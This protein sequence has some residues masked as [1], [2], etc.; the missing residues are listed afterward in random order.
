MK[1]NYIFMMCCTAMPELLLKVSAYYTTLNSRMWV[2]QPTKNQP[3]SPNSDPNSLN[4]SLLTFCFFCLMTKE[5]NYQSVKWPP[6]LMEGI[7]EH[8]LCSGQS[9]V[10]FKTKW[11]NQKGPLISEQPMYPSDSSTTTGSHRVS[12][13]SGQWGELKHSSCSGLWSGSS[14][15]AGA[16][17]QSH[18][19]IHRLPGTPTCPLLRCLNATRATSIHH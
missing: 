16:L 18:T 11:N 3:D 14:D 9:R 8:W 7:S 6:A 15:A 2:T 17:L 5:Q 19:C 4:T 12:W 13:G 10:R 1:I